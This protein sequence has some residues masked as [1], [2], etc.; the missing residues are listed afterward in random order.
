MGRYDLRPANTVA[1][2]A[3]I[4]VDRA[5]L[6]GMMAEHRFG[7]DELPTQYQAGSLSRPLSELSLP[8][9]W[10]SASLRV[11]NRRPGA[12]L[13]FKGLDLREGWIV[14]RMTVSADG[15]DR[16][17]PLHSLGLAMGGLLRFRRAFAGSSL[18]PERPAPSTARRG[19][20][21]STSWFRPAGT[22]R[23]RPASGSGPDCHQ[24]CG[25]SCWDTALA[26]CGS[27]SRH[28]ASRASS[29]SGSSG[30]SVPAPGEAV[31]GS[32]HS[33]PPPSSQR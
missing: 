27:A 6:I 21:K 26:A 10:L 24:R 18:R 17:D 20:R 5:R 8:D 31:N 23:S 3:A 16:R 19:L 15:C 30:K 12:A 33:A 28:W 14:P 11:T 22:S 4:P 2:C 13:I 7:L 29:S 1:A 25:P 9:S 32:R